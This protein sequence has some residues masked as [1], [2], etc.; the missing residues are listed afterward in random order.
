MVQTQRQSL[1]AVVESAQR[2]RQSL[3]GQLQD[4]RNYQQSLQGQLQVSHV[5]RQSL[6]SQLQAVEVE[7]QSRQIL[8]ETELKSAQ[9]ET[10][11]AFTLLEERTKA[12]AA[13]HKAMIENLDSQ[14]AFLRREIL[15]L[16]SNDGIDTT[17]QSVS[18]L[19]CSELEAKLLIQ[20]IQGR[21]L[22]PKP[23]QTSK[24][25]IRTECRF[26]WLHLPSYPITKLS[27]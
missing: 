7:L 16:R 9:S 1:Q 24:T 26:R 14:I 18:F 5:E 17:G 3:Q 11:T 25:R 6:R 8:F 2:E 12:S 15:E 10:K 13:S 21:N 22:A 19:S 27:R 23:G 4:L 20:S